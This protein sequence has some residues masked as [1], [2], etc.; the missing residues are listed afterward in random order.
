M[1]R[2]PSRFVP[3][4]IA[5]ASWRSKRPRSTAASR[6]L[7]TGPIRCGT[8]PTSLTGQVLVSMW[9]HR[10]ASPLRPRRC[11]K[12]F[13]DFTDSCAVMTNAMARFDAAVSRL[14]T[15]LESDGS[16]SEAEG[17]LNPAC[18]RAPGGELLLYPRVVAAGN[19]SRVGLFRNAGAGD[20]VRLE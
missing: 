7:L 6:R 11:A 19:V 1:C 16:P 3:T 5:S 8:F 13:D 17:V 12:E 18:V 10:R 4:P 20:N 2:S 9:S 14:G 15:V